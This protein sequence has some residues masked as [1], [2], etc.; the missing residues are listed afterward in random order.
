MA[1]FLAAFYKVRAFAT[2]AMYTS[3]RDSPVYIYKPARHTYMMCA[4]IYTYTWCTR[5]GASERIYAN[6]GNYTAR[7]R[8]F[9]LGRDAGV[10]YLGAY[11]F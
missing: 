4:S 2:H 11:L 10:I 8:G 1:V 7:A 6:R 3:L 9:D 5:G